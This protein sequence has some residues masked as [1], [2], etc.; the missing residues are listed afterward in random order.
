MKKADCYLVYSGDGDVE[1]FAQRFLNGGGRHAVRLETFIEAF[2]ERFGFR[3]E[4]IYG[5]RRVELLNKNARMRVYRVMNGFIRERA[6]PDE[7]ETV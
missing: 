2:R 7:E 1:N 6:L 3:P 4:V 5:K